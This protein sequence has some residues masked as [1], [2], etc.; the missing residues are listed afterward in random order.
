VKKRKGNERKGK[1]RKRKEKKE[2]NP[3]DLQRLT[4]NHAA[5]S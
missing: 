1:R 2:A 4:D 5:H 3:F